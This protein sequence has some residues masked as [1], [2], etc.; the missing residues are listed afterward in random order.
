MKV[1]QVEK[2]FKPVTISITFESEEE[3]R[4]MYNIFNHSDILD[5]AENT[6]AAMERVHA[7]LSDLS[8]SYQVRNFNDF[9]DDLRRRIHRDEI[10][11]T[12]KA[13]I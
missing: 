2:G 13:I 7:C 5:A 11:N 8:D 1:N 4:T 6:G 3:I 12:A 9:A 10:S